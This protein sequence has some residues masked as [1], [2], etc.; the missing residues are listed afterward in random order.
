MWKENPVECDPEFPSQ[1]LDEATLYVPIGTKYKYTKV[2]PWRNFWNIQ[3]KDFSGVD[4]VVADDVNVKIV[5]GCI[6]VGGNDP[7]CVYDM[8]G[9]TV[10]SGNPKRIEN[11]PAGLYIVTCA[12]KSVKVVV[13]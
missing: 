13:P 12:G 7:V 11:V 2:D 8:Q 10:Y 1:V 9:R 4:S 5:D 6:C 3:E